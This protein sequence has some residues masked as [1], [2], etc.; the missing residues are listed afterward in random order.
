MKK[1]RRMRRQRQPRGEK[2]EVQRAPNTGPDRFTVERFMGGVGDAVANDLTLLALR[3]GYQISAR[4]LHVQVLP[5]VLILACYSRY[6]EDV[7]LV[8][9]Y[10]RLLDEVKQNIADFAHP[11]K[12]LASCIHILAQR[13]QYP[14]L[15]AFEAV[16]V[17]NIY[18][19]LI[20]VE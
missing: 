5:A 2:K 9:D 19:E 10:D 7:E 20:Q 12:Y 4:S 17:P 16:G 8:D 18:N 1:Q 14:S 13:E 3:S 11:D 6:Y 15:E